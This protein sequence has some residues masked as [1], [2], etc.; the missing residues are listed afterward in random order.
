MV[1]TLY[2][3]GELPKDIGKI[4]RNSTR[5]RQVKKKQLSYDEIKTEPEIGDN[6]NIRRYNFGTA[7]QLEDDSLDDYFY[8]LEILAKDCDYNDM[9]ND[10]IRDRFIIGINDTHLR[11]KL[12]KFENLTINSLIAIANITIK[13]EIEFV[14]V[15]DEQLKIE[16]DELMPEIKL[17]E[18]PN[19]E[20][21]NSPVKIKESFVKILS[22]KPLEPLNKNK[23]HKC[24]ETFR[25]PNY[26]FQH[27]LLMHSLK[28]LCKIC[29]AKFHSSEDLM[30]HVNI[31]HKPGHTT[32]GTT[33]KNPTHIPEPDDNYYYSDD[34]CI[35]AK[36]I[37]TYPYMC[38]LCAKIIKNPQQLASHKMEHEGIKPYLC[39]VC[40]LRFRIGNTLRRHEMVHSGEKPF[41]CGICTKS[42]A[43]SYAL[44]T[45]MRRIHKV[46][47]TKVE[48]E[49]KK[50][51][52]FETATLKDVTLN[53]NFDAFED[54]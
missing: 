39:T 5:L 50:K 48:K 38:E 14:T 7:I 44:T 28:F 27:I 43:R 6:L 25:S 33:A 9:K 11:E 16:I 46:V 13:K 24:N 35:S 26:L 31:Y 52:T 12:L 40:G 15:I 45:H 10:L 20:S 47:K 4:P 51:D 36:K 3:N 42:F 21:Q 32:A 23:C 30:L 8:R 1:P 22:N 29:K 53:I 18:N 54:N 34:S 19:K 37:Y 17:E 2:L 49:L 41:S